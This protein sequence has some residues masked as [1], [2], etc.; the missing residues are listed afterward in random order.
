MAVCYLWEFAGA[1]SWVGAALAVVMG[2]GPTIGVGE[3]RTAAGNLLEKNRATARATASAIDCW[4]SGLRSF[5][6][7]SG[8]EMKATSTKTAGIVAPT[9]TRK[10]AC[11]MPRLPVSETAFNS[12]WI[13]SASSL[14]SFR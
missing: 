10:G 2:D 13:A 6:S 1:A 11:L 12:T 5:F 4:N 7:W 8:L 9:S 14:D 3:F